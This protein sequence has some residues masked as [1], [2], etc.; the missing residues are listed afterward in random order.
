[1][2]KKK[3]VKIAKN[4]KALGGTNGLSTKNIIKNYPFSRNGKV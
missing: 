4:G 1:M 3:R 2:F